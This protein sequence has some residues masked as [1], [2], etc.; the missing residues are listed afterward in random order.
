MSMGWLLGDLGDMSMGPNVREWNVCMEPDHAREEK[1]LLRPCGW[2][3]CAWA[4]PVG[5][6]LEKISLQLVG[7]FCAWAAGQ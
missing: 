1:K 7:P 4:W 6:L 5:A 3:G 2:K